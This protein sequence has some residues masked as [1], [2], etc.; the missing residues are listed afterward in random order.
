MNSLAYAKEHGH[1]P[2]FLSFFGLNSPQLLNQD[3]WQQKMNVAICHTGNSMNSKKII[4]FSDTVKIDALLAYR[5]AVGL[6]TREITLQL[7]PNALKQKVDPICIQRVMNEGAIIK[8]ACG[9]ANYRSKRTIAGLLL[10]PATRH[11]NV[12][13][14]EALKLKLT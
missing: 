7:T 2:S 10:M 1:L 11:N 14:N 6:R 9:I 4:S 5:L 12:H 8:E 13:L 3:N